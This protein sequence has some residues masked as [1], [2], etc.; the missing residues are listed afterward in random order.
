MFMAF[1]PGPVQQSPRQVAQG[2]KVQTQV[3]V[4]GGAGSAGQAL[5]AGKTKQSGKSQGKRK[6]GGAASGGGR[7]AAAAGGGK[8]AKRAKK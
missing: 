5:E 2:R 8:G 6:A 7:A 4:L 1:R 3:A